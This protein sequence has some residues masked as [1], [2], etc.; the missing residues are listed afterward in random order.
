MHLGLVQIN[1]HLGA[2]D[3]NLQVILSYIE[4]A[5][6]AGCDLVVFPELA[7]CGSPP[8]DLLWRSGFVEKMEG[9]LS[10]IVRASK[11]IGVI[12]GGVSSRAKKGRANLADRSS[13]SDGAGIDLFNSAF[14]FV[15]G[16]L[17]GEEAKLMLPTFDVYSEERYFTPAPARRSSS[18]EGCASGSMCA[19][20]CGSMMD[21]PI[22][23]RA[24]A[25]TG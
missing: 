13:L 23:R 19:R 24:W 15:D 7:I 5:R 14:L 1:P 2:I 16:V 8:L 22:P 17:V 4:K 21:R 9:A 18:S 20:I 3:R 10:E 11:R 25:Q 6:K 12:V